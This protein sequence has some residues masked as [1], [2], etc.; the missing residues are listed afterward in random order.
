M[1]D[2]VNRSGPFDI[3]ESDTS[4]FSDEKHLA[5]VIS[6]LGPLPVDILRQA[7]KRSAIF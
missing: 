6:I 7:K 2:L 5:H 3:Q 4:H 1:L